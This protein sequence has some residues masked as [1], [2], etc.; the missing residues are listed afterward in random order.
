V[1]EERPLLTLLS[2]EHFYDRSAR[3]GNWFA[4]WVFVAL[5]AVLVGIAVALLEGAKDIRLS[6]LLVLAAV[7]GAIAGAVWII[8]FNRTHYRV[9][10]RAVERITVWPRRS[11]RVGVEDIEN[12]VLEASHGHWILWL[13]LRGGLRRKIG[14]TRSMREKLSL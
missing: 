1:D 7:M 11:W 8:T 13:K 9:S 12:T 5:P 10:D 4:L 6:P 3:L 14:L 2:G